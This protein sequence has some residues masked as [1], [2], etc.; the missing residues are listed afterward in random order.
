MPTPPATK[1]H[2]F[3][4]Y[5]RDNRAE[6]QQLHDDLVAA[7]ETVWWD[8]LI[9][10][11]EDWKQSIRR[12]MKAS[13]AVVLCLSKEFEQR[14]ASGVYPEILDAIT[15]YRQHAPGSIYLVPVKLSDCA[16][17]DIEIDDTR[18]LDR[19]QCVDL[20]PPKQRKTGFA[21]LVDALKAT[22]GHP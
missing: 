5:C 2:V 1:K 10:P 8:Q 22:A 20:F 21:K 13:Y 19:L 16:T 14:V 11:G 6:V 15:A 4:S 3:L 17:P 7:G 12:A 18:T 9:K